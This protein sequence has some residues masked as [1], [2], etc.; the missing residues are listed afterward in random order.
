VAFDDGAIAN[1]TFSYDD[2]TRTVANWNVR[3]TG[4][5]LFLAVTYTP[6]NSAGYYTTPWTY[7]VSDAAPPG[8]YRVLN[9]APAAPLDGSSKVV[10][11]DLAMSYEA[12]EEL[13]VR[14]RR[15]VS[16]GSLV[17]TAAAPPT[18]MV[19]V[20]EFYNEA[21]RHYFI[22]ADPL[23]KHDLD[24]GIHVGWVRTGKSF[25]AYATG[26]RASGSINPVCRYYT[27]PLET[28][29]S[30]FYSG[31]AKECLTVH[32]KFGSDWLFESD[33]VFQ[34]N[35]PDKATGVC[36][37]GTVSVYRL[38]NTRVDSNHRY[39]TSAA[40]RDE[41]LAAGYVAEGYGPDSVAMCALK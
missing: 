16:S 37:R 35:F 18:A 27:N 38:W 25:R 39:T 11:L 24:A 36:P 14:G 40:I 32:L 33:N 19:Q 29:A 22:T 34:I 6:G 8:L 23:E 13:I 15:N 2:D 1:G 41:M 17:L 20:D 30:H 21:T 9:I 12:Y 7:F 31:D 4:G 3:V 26:S 28:L 10:A 5:P